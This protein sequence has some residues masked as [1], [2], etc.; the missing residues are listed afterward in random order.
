MTGPTV[1]E[2]DLIAA[3]V[4]EAAG[5]WFA[6]LTSPFTGVLAQLAERLAAA[7]GTTVAAAEQ[8]IRWAV[9]RCRAGEN[10][11][12]RAGEWATLADG[13]DGLIADVCRF[14]GELADL[15]EE[16]R[17]LCR[18][19]AQLAVGSRD[20]GVPVR[21]IADAAGVNP[22]AV[23]GWLTDP[24][25]ASD[26]LPIGSHRLLDRLASVAGEI[27]GVAVVQRLVYT[28]RRAAFAAARQLDPPVCWSDLAAAAGI[29][30]AAVK[31]ALRRRDHQ[32][33]DTDQEDR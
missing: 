8:R 29:T 7:T 20:A 11:V 10:R 1:L 2:D 23:P 22:T 5:V 32:T 12:Q 3:A 15:A 27:A 16:R 14:A 31:Q 30:P 19:R 13:R 25:V 33:D 24:T 9:I 26:L 6:D 18:R 21:R 4:A 28:D 17:F